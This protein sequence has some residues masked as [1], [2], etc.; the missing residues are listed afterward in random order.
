MLLGLKTGIGDCSYK[1]A[2]P[3]IPIASAEIISRLL[4]VLEILDRKYLR[5]SQTVATLFA[6]SCIFLS[7][8]IT[9]YGCDFF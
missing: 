1:A 7:L 6:L 5:L 9:L 8:R 3:D 4:C 2:A